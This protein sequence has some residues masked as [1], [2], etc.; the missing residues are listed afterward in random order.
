MALLKRGACALGLTAL[1]AVPLETAALAQSRPSEAGEYV[2]KAAILYNLLKFVEWPADAFSAATAPVSVCLIGADPFGPQ[3][4]DSV[5]GR[6]V[7]GRPI[8]VHRLTEVTAGC[9]VLF[10]S[11]SETRRLPVIL[12]RLGAASVLTVS[13][14]EGFADRGGMIELRTAR[15]GVTFRIGLDAAD[16]ARLHLSARLLALAAPSRLQPRGAR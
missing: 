9:Q 14:Q 12:D 5:K 8:V 4:D 7:G 13:E 15:D 6:Q 11:T 16:R 1:L 3:I 10:I 2:L